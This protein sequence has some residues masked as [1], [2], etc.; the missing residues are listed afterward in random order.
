MIPNMSTD[1]EVEDQAFDEWLVT[2]GVVNVQAIS[3]E[4]SEGKVDQND[5]QSDDGKEKMDF[6]LTTK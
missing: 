4:G 2:Q 5:E 6:A 3:T 1:L